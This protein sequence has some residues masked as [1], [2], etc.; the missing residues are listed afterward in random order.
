M[1]RPRLLRTKD[2][3]EISLK[4]VSNELYDK[5]KLL[6]DGKEDAGSATEEAPTMSTDAGICLETA[7][8][9]HRLS[10]G[11][12]YGTAVVRYNPETKAAYVEEVNTFEDQYGAI[13]NF[14]ILAVDNK[15]V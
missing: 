1:A 11:I 2:G 9:S 5:I 15:L 10:D 12:R 3:G 8:G 7:I 4:N 13:D 6:V 14:K